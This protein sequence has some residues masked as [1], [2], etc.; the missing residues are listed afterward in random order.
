MRRPVWR[1]G[2]C[3]ARLPHRRRGRETRNCGGA[4]S[5]GWAADSDATVRSRHVLNLHESA[6]GGTGVTGDG[7][8]TGRETHEDSGAPAAGGKPEGADRRDFYRC[9][10]RKRTTGE[11]TPPWPRR[12]PLWRRCWVPTPL[13]KGMRPK[14]RRSRRPRA[15]GG[16]LAQA[17]G[18]PTDAAAVG[19]PPFPE[20]H[21]HRSVASPL[22]A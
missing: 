5:W 15:D 19:K 3:R 16:A 20:K 12:R 2:R 13:G 6:A 7:G 22:D 4:C 14:S 10:L 8:S 9:A 21:D 18:L 11:R 1:R 17:P